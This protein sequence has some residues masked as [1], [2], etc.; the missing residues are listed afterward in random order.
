MFSRVFPRGKKHKNASITKVI[1]VTTG[2]FTAPSVRF[3]VPLFHSKQPPSAKW[4]AAPLCPGFCKEAG[5][6]MGGVKLLVGGE[7]PSEHEK[8]M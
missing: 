5:D 6:P 3:P 8:N 7:K 2:I 4:A 1:K